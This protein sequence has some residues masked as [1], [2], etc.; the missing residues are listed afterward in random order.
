VERPVRPRP[1]PVVPWG[2]GLGVARLR[3][4]GAVDWGRRVCGSWGGGLGAHGDGLEA[5][6]RDYSP[7]VGAGGA[8][9]VCSLKAVACPADSTA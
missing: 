4:R 3:F 7:D 2:G 5:G 9:S 8:G 6:Q 1:R